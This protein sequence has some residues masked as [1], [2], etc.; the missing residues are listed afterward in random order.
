M[1]TGVKLRSLKRSGEGDKMVEYRMKEDVRSIVHTQI[2]VNQ[3]V[4]ATTVTQ[5]TGQPALS[6]IGA[7][8]R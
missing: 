2:R 1:Q 6:H 8:G 4:E 3:A 7:A 5:L